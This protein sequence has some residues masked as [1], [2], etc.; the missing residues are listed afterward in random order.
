MIDWIR[1]TLVA[2]GTISPSDV[3]LI[4]I[5]DDPAEAVRIVAEGSAKHHNP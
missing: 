1:T 4:R 2:E 5:T 3:G